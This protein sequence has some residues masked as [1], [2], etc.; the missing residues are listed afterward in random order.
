MSEQEIFEWEFHGRRVL[1]PVRR[2]TDFIIGLALLSAGL[3]GYFLSD[4]KITPFYGTFMAGGLI[5]LISAFTG[6][7]FIKERCYIRID[8]DQIE[9]K[10][11]FRKAR[12]LSK[13][14]LLGI[15][16]EPDKIEFVLKD[17]KLFT[18]DCSLFK[19]EEQD[20]LRSALET[21]NSMLMQ[22]D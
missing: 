3:A 12:T 7:V 20:T 13:N 19:K 2:K 9:Y 10:N 11:A 6:K 15:R 18:F 8:K 21:E 22:K 16:I 17:H 14:E 4:V 1:Q 5:S